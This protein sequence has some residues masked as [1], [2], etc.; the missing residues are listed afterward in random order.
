MAIADI[1][2]TLTQIDPLFSSVTYPT[3]VEPWIELTVPEVN[4]TTFSGL[5]ANAV[6]NLVAHKMASNF[7][8]AQ[9]A[10]GGAGGTPAELRA[11]KWSIRYQQGA[12]AA[13]QDSDAVLNETRYGREYLRLRGMCSGFPRLLSPMTI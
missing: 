8:A 2:Q 4:S 12:A 9:A 6:A 7:A 13:S 10:L 5:Y 3:D 1:V 11:G